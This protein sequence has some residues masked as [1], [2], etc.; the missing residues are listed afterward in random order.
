M[1][2]II[3]G[4]GERANRLYPHIGEENV[5][6]FI[7]SNKEKRGQTFLN[8]KIISFEEYKDLYSQYYI[9]ISC[10]Q[11]QEVETILLKN[12]IYKYFKM[13]D[14]PGEFQESYSRT[15][16]YKYIYNTISKES[17]YAIYGC[18]LYSFILNEWIE[19]KTGKKAII[20]PSFDIDINFYNSIIEDF[21][22]EKF[23]DFDSISNFRID[24]ILVTYENDLNMIKKKLGTSYGIRNVY[25]CSD[26]IE[27]YY[28]PQIESFKNIHQGKRC[29]IVATGPSLNMDDLERLRTNDEI[30]LSMNSIWRAFDKVEWRPYYYL[31]E[32]YRT[33]NQYGAVMENMN[34]RYLF[35]GD[36]NK[37]YW[38]KEHKKNMIKYHYAFEFSEVKCPKFTEDFSRK[39]YAGAT[40]TYSCI[41]LAV[42][43]G[44]QEIYLLGVDFTNGKNSNNEN[45][46]HF[47]KEEKLTS[48]GHNKM[49][50]LAYQSAKKYADAHGIKIYNA[51]RGGNLDVFERRDFDQLF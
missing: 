24:D 21:C 34:V 15:L 38:S 49:V 13:S 40:V 10:L 23:I 32:D 42:Y 51:T 50:Y 29:F 2:Y 11:E 22:D 5:L 47:Y 33:Y 48:V 3:W 41:Q 19:Q 30:C 17:E 37:V 26:K 16:L 12:R 6:A 18:T 31:A 43:M 25:D 35:L 36:T 45:Y 7:D 28:N 8:K 27:E 14:C 1:K 9:V 39:C 4:A 20:I 46:K 44:F